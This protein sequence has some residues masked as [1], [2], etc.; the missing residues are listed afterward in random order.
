MATGADT[1]ERQCTESFIQNRMFWFWS[2]IGYWPIMPNVYVWHN[3]SDLAAKTKAGYTCE[4]EI[5]LSRSDFLADAKKHERRYHLGGA[6]PEWWRRLPERGIGTGPSYFS[7]CTPVD[8]VTL[9]DLPRETDGLYYVEPMAKRYR[10][11][12]VHTIRKPTKL[13]RE[14]DDGRL[15]RACA[16]AAEARF[17][18]MR[19]ALAESED[20][21]RREVR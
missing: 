8:L 14:K 13:H 11:A 3:E 16:K 19:L 7:W 9:D 4:L 5:K 12:L 18:R 2:E 17:W 10:G 6:A 21:A 20:R 1:I 15:E